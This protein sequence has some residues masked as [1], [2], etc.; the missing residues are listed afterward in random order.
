MDRRPLTTA[1]SCL[2]KLEAGGE[3]G[4]GKLAADGRK[5]Q[6]QIASAYR[7]TE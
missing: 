1:C 3:V 2:Q 5:S 6:S 7:K 4:L